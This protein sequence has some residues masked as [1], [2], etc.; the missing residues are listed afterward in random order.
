MIHAGFQIGASVP[1]VVGIRK[2]V[3]GIRTLEAGRTKRERVLEDRDGFV[4]KRGILGL[5][6]LPNE[7]STFGVE[8]LAD[9][10]W[11]AV[12]IKLS[13]VCVDTRR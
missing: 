12:E 10:S 5:V 1:I 2:T 9:H 6:V 11:L 7:D 13:M 4:Q 3:Q 8:D